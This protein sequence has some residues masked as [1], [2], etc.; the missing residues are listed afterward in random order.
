[1]DSDTIALMTASL[2][3][4]ED[5]PPVAV[6]DEENL[7][8]ETNRLS[9]SLVCKVLS[10]KTINRDAFHSTIMKSWKLDMALAIESLGNNRFICKL[11]QIRI[12]AMFYWMVPEI[13]LML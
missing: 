9:Q 6:F 4:D 8:P 5:P 13:S 10:Y 3:L 1:M 7:S 2:N 12:N 11:I